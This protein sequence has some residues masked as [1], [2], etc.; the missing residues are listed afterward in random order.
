LFPDVGNYIKTHVVASV[1]K[2]VLLLE[3]FNNSNLHE[4]AYLESE[5]KTEG[6]EMCQIL[7]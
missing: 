1:L 4:A 2:Y 5:T 7:Q 6:V 3:S